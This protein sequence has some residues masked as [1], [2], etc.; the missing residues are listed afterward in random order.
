MMDES[1][2][3]ADTHIRLLAGH[4]STGRPVFEVLP[5]R[6]LGDHSF[7]LSGS[8]GLVL[9]CAAGDVLQVAGDGTY[10]ATERGANVCVQA[11]RRGPFSS[12]ELAGLEAAPTALDGLA[13]APAD[14]RFIVGTVAREVG[15]PAIER[16]MNDWAASVDNTEWW[17]G[18]A[19]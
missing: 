4:S 9:G 13:E 12:E 1:N 7:E 2:V 15:F 18:N 8:P 14:R 17:F 10:E 11:Y 6:V 19:D 16:V 3:G 5:A